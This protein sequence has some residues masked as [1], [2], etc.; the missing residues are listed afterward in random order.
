MQC[1]SLVGRQRELREDRDVLFKNLAHL[2]GLSRKGCVRE[3]NESIGK[4]L[5]MRADDEANDPM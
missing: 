5:R 4:Y 2:W 1:F 3:I